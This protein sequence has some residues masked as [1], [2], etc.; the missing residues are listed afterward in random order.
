MKAFVLMNKKTG[1][2]M[3]AYRIVF[4]D[5]PVQELILGA[6]I[7]VLELSYDGWLL[8]HP[9]LGITPLFFNRHCEKWFENLG[10]L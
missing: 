1:D 5:K 10:E 9:Q 6:Q 2:L 7:G 8:I 4:F 3:E